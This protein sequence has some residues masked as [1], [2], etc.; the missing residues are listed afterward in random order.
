MPWANVPEDKWPD[1]ERC[2]EKVMGDGKDKESATAIC[3]TSVMG[4]SLDIKAGRRHSESDMSMGRQV[5]QMA[6]QIVGH[7]DALGFTDEAMPAEWSPDMDMPEKA[8]VFAGTEVKALG[9]GRVGGYLVRFTSADSPD[10]TGDYFTAAT[11]FGEHDTAPVFYQHGLDDVLKNRQLGKGKLRKDDVGMWVEAQLALRDEY[12]KAI[13][14]MAENNKLGWSSGTATHLVQRELTGKAYRIKSWPLGLDASL[15]P[16]PA[17]PRNSAMTLKAYVDSLHPAPPPNGDPAPAPNGAQDATPAVPVPVPSVQEKKKMADETTA[18]SPEMTAE[19]KKLMDSL[20]AITD[21]MTTV[22]KDVDAMKAEP[23]IKS[24]GVAAP[25]FNKLPKESYADEQLSALKALLRGEIG[26]DEWK[27]HQEFVKQHGGSEAKAWTD[28]MRNPFDPQ[29]RA[30]FEAAMK[31]SML[32][33]T[34]SLGG[35]LVPALYSNQVIGTLKEQSVVRAA[36]AYQFPVSGTNSF[37]VPKITRSGS[38]PLA[39]EMG[40]ASQMEPTFANQA[41]VPYAYRAQYIAS[42]EV[43][44]DTRIPLDALLM[45]NASWQLTQSENVAFTIGTGSSQPQGIAAAASTLGLSP[46]STLALAFPNG[47]VGGDLLVDIY[48]GLPYQYRPGAA[49]FMHDTV[50]KS[51]RKLREGGAAAST[52]NFL[53]QPGLQAGDPDRIFGKPVYIANNMSTTGSTANIIAFGDPRFFWIADFNNG[54]MDF[55]VLNELYAA[56]AAVGWW[57]WRRIDSHLLVSEAVVGLKLLT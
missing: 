11:D 42:R 18:L 12:E 14:S 2:V 20:I 19:F 39:S 50:A 48:H 53:W 10:L 51:I 17:E 16:T 31:A 56:S 38:A 40:A 35:N 28:Y 49:W 52:G 3:Y 25:A 36:G 45:D 55:Q 26:K 21:Q 29:K 44:L 24:G 57:F 7:M 9:D 13:Y 6:G 46:G 54:G 33:G 34:A 8:L 5:K 22:K 1:M 27:K 4:K 47:V 23:A 32:E 41:F 43:A 37:N 30:D 15:T